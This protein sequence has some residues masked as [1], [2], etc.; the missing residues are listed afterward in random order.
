DLFTHPQVVPTSAYLWD[1]AE[2]IR[3]FLGNPHPVYTL[4]NA[5]ISG[6]L[7]I[8]IA[9]RFIRSGR[10]DSAIVVGA[11]LFSHFVL[12]GFKSFQALS[13]APCKPFDANRTGINLG[14]AGAS[15]ILTRSDR[16]S[17]GKVNVLGGA[18]S[19][20]ANHI[21]GPSRT[22]DGL[23]YAIQAAL[24]SSHITSSLEIDYISAHGTGTS[25][26]DEMEA[27]AFA[28][29][30]LTQVPTNSLKGYFG[31]T[32]GTSGILESV[33]AVD[34]IENSRLFASAGY[35]VRGVSESL[36][37][38]T[39]NTFGKLTTCLK[40]SSGF[41]SCNAALVLSTKSL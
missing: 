17:Q 6:T 22:G 32:L 16:T 1:S 5:C 23:Y 20:D 35:E 8:V 14:E 11:D 10:Y 39:E 37:I 19:N 28:W 26:N 12:S 40:T 3:T 21:S 36:N 7:A 38:L 25:Y 18:S 29:A 27:K 24:E 2:K 41:G 30:G 31:H 13:P 34:S 33:L 15:L 9:A 4:S